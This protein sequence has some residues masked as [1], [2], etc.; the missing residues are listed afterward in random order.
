MK[1]L[2]LIAFCAVALATVDERLARLE[3]ENQVISAEINTLDSTLE[4]I[5]KARKLVL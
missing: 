4:A 2:L 5:K 3:H 1:L